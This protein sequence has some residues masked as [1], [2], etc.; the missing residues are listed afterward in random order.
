MIR[1]FR[2]LA[3]LLEDIRR[4]RE[5]MQGRGQYVSVRGVQRAVGRA[6]AHRRGL[7]R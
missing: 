6:E 4:W 2:R 5:E 7:E 1:F 3:I